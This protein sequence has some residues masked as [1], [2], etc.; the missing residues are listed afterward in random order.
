MYRLVQYHLFH[1]L[2]STCLLHFIN[3]Y[4]VG[5]LAYAALIAVRQVMGPA[6][7]A[8]S[9]AAAMAK[10]S[11]NRPLQRQLMPPYGETMPGCFIVLF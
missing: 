7:L 3:T 10:A 1:T 8:P 11:L 4:K 2:A 6:S 9:M 5:A